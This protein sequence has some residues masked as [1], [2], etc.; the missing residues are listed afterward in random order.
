MTNHHIKLADL[1]GEILD[2]AKTLVREHF[3]EFGL[4][5]I[6]EN[7]EGSPHVDTKSIYLRAPPWPFKSLRDAQ[8]DTRVV[9]WPALQL[10]RRFDAVLTALQH[11]VGMPLAR[12]LVV[13]LH[14]GGSIKSHRDEGQY[15]EQTERF[16]YPIETNDKAVSKIGD[17]E[18]N[19]PEGTVWWYDKTVEH[20]AKNDGES[21]RIHI[22]FD[23]WRPQ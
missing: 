17:E 8:N 1:G 18:I 23:C 5:D 12:V 6:R 2:V 7:H 20:S 11:V 15:A 14:A 22:I 10:D 21:G 13:D 9:N 19:M 3:D 4:V 16:H